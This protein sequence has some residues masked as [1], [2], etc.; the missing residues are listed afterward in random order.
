MVDFYKLSFDKIKSYKKN[1]KD[2][3]V[4]NYLTNI[5]KI[6]RE[7][8]NSEKPSIQY[9]RDFDSIKE[10]I[11]KR[12][13]NYASKKNLVTSIVV[14]LKAYSVD[15]KV[16][17]KYSEYH[18]TLSKTHDD[19][20]LDNEKTDKEQQNWISSKDIQEKF[21]FLEEQIKNKIGITKRKYADLIQQYLVLCLYTKIP[22]IRND[23]ALSRVIN[24]DNNL[25]CS[26][27]HFIL[28]SEEFV[29][30]KYKTD[31]FYGIKRV[32]IPE[33]VIVI[34]K[35]WEK[36]KKEIFGDKLDHDFLLINTTNLLPMKK[37]SL[38]KYI[39]KIFYP[40]KVSTT[41]LRKVYLSEKYP[42]TNTY[43]EM[44]NDSYIMGHDISVAKKI[45][46]KIL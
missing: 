4:N 35:K 22:P 5:R 15:C 36:I 2:V 26:E 45:Y 17:E 27:N 38:T 8:F 37:N 34:I 20:Y 40:K 21:Q 10:Y 24:D 23:Y 12:I 28:G 11:D 7:L 1:I 44:Q 16:I 6:S 25:K 13:K 3:S 33:D 30:C 46:S 14:L 32:K 41:I 19:S 39:N 18:K 29:L 43:R 9:F 31:K 42:V